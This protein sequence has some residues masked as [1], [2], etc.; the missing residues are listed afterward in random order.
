MARR[1]ITLDDDLVRW[2]R[3]EAGRRETTVPKLVRR[4][5][6]ERMEFELGYEAAMRRYL[7]GSGGPGDAE[8]RRNTEAP[9]PHHSSALR[10]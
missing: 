2:L 1:R 9:A 3:R 5:L 6:R 4:F 7:S 10:S 8:G